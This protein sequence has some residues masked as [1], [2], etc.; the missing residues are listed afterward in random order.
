MEK[1]DKKLFNSYLRNHT[2]EK[3]I[4][5]CK[6]KNLSTV[7]TKADMVLRI[8]N[9]N[10]PIISFSN[11]KTVVTEEK[12]PQKTILPT[13]NTIKILKNKFNHYCHNESKLV[14]DMTSKRVIGVQLDNGNIR[15]LKRDDIELCKLYKF[16]YNLPETLEQVYDILENSDIEDV[17]ESISEESENELYEDNEENE[18]DL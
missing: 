11:S 3:L 4:E 14:F 16:K 2:K 10:T 9:V 7:G 6:S 12:S 15:S 1:T 5:E 17:S 8:L 18:D 13:I